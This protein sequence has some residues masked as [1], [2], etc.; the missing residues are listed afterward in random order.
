[1]PGVKNKNNN[2][3]KLLI[4]HRFQPALIPAPGPVHLAVAAEAADS[5]R[6]FLRA[7]AA[8]LRDPRSLRLFRPLHLPA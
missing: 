2:A 4:A 5:G 6:P 1:M 8:G 3:K 7:H